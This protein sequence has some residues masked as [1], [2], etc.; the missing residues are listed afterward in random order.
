MQTIENPSGTALPSDI[1]VESMQDAVARVHS[2]VESELARDI[3]PERI[4]L[5]GFSQGCAISLLSMLSS[6]HKLGGLLCMSGW[7]PMINQIH[8]S[9]NGTMHPVSPVRVSSSDCMSSTIDLST[10]SR[11]KI[12]IRSP[13]PFSGVTAGMT[14]L[15]LRHGPRLAA[16]H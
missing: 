11:C 12:L 16:K 10:P 3:L 7:L 4:V 14:R 6:K 15:Y 9:S 8:R 1:D 5:A 13:S 2:V